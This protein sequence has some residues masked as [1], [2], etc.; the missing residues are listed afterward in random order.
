MAAE[1]NTDNYVPLA[2][3]ANG[4][5]SGKGTTPYATVVGRLKREWG[6]S[7]MKKHGYVLYLAHPDFEIC[8]V[9]GDV[10]T[11]IIDGHH[12]KLI[13]LE[14]HRPVEWSRDGDQHVGKLVNREARLTEWVSALGSEYL[15]R[16]DGESK[17]AVGG[18][19]RKDLLKRAKAAAEKYLKT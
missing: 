9:T 11:P 6:S 5:Q 13:K 19:D 7:H 15:I 8:G 17:G 2:M 16:I 14:D 10:R 18:G 3:T 12:H 4:W 1:I